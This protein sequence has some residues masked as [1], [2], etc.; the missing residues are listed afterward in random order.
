MGRKGLF[1]IL[2]CFSL[3]TLE[4]QSLYQQN[5]DVGLGDMTAIDNDGK[6]PWN[7]VAQF[8]SNWM[9]FPAGTFGTTSGVVL[10]NSWFEPA[11]RAD[12]WLISSG[13]DITGDALLQWEAISGDN[14]VK[15]NYRV[16][17]STTGPEI[18]NFTDEL[19][20]VPAELGLNFT[21]RR[22]DLSAYQGQKIWFAFNNISNDRFILII[23]NIEVFVP[24]ARDARIL[25]IS[26]SESNLANAK[27][28][29]LAGE[30]NLV[31][32]INNHGFER[33]ET[34]TIE[35]SLNGVEFEETIDVGLDPYET[36]TWTSNEKFEFSVGPNQPI[37]NI[38]KVNGIDD[39]NS[40]N[41]EAVGSIR[42]YPP[43]PDFFTTDADGNTY[44]M[45]ATLGSGK[46]VLLYFL[47]SGCPDCPT[48]TSDVNTF[49]DAYGGGNDKFEVVGITTDPNDNAATLNNLGWNA[50]FPLIPYSPLNTVYYTHFDKNH[51]LGNGQEPLYVLLCPN[52]TNSAFS[53]IIQ[54]ATEFNAS[55]FEGPLNICINGVGIN[56]IK[57]LSDMSIYPN[58]TETE[59]LTLEFNLD[60]NAEMG[61]QIINVQGKLIKDFG[62]EHYIQG[63]NTKTLN[64]SELNV[65]LYF[66]QISNKEHTSTYKINIIR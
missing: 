2:F 57:I 58:P 5:F 6:T 35:Y 1:V 30:Q 47:N 46:A 44:N 34:V 38:K 31:A 40:S 7:T 42:A 50:T 56:E 64:I 49:Y 39:E 11:G 62:Y 65:G 32:E 61:L 12:D 21:Q 26:S 36:F 14:S 53:T 59:D 27:Y 29:C 43:V 22:V 9:V 66:L 19:L 51:K 20:E 24:F 45:L 28:I 41:D 10:S 13:I 8:G 33:M 3:L 4:S 52:P 18:I 54:S 16:M 48:E 23:D 37:I 15:D 60:K 55:D 25:D 63:N 17:V